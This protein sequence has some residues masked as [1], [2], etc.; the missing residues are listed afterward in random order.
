MLS[1][2][3]LGI[4]TSSVFALAAAGCG[5]SLP[6]MSTGSL[7]GGSAA[8]TAA[9]AAPQVQNDPTSRALQVGTT[10]ARAQKCGFNFD[11]NKLRTQFLAAEG[12]TLTNAN[13]ITK[14]TQSYDASYRGT[15]R[16]LTGE[17]EAY[18]SPQ[19]T[20]TIKTALTRH[21]AGDFSPAPPEPVAEEESLFGGFGSSS[22]NEE[23]I[24]KLR[25]PPVGDQ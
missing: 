13:D 9:T 2:R 18:C 5:A 22:N 11:A 12:A 21:L 17:G 14:L 6:G 8:S 25:H 20:Q 3:L 7:F 24:N 23:N 16:A 4:A 1:H 10:A 15:T 19:K